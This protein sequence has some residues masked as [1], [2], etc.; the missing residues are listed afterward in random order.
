[1][2]TMCLQFPD[3]SVRWLITGK[4]LPIGRHANVVVESELGSSG[5]YKIQ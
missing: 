3:S 2:L 4:H 5:T 1:M